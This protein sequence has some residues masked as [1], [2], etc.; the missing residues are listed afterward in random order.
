MS[1][2]LLTSND[3]SWVA[4]LIRPFYRGSLSDEQV[5]Q[6]I[7]DTTH[8]VI[9]FGDPD[10]VTPVGKG[11]IGQL[12]HYK[13][14]P[15]FP[16]PFL[17]GKLATQVNLLGPLPFGTPAANTFL[18]DTMLPLLAHVLHKISLRFPVVANRP[19]WAFG[20]KTVVD[21]MLLKFPNAKALSVTGGYSYVWHTKLNDADN[22]VAEVRP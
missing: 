15:D 14:E 11:M 16:V 19:V 10:V 20:D 21:L 1:L 5:V 2:R 8:P 22:A 13:L 17:Q 9:T 6:M 12:K 4:P 7:T 3:A 18:V